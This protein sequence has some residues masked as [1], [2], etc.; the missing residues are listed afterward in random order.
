[1]RKVDEAA[2]TVGGDTSGI[3]YPTLPP[4][5]EIDEYC[6]LVTPPPGMDAARRDAHLLSRR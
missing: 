1:M 2:R 6:K 5:D 3:Q 4:S